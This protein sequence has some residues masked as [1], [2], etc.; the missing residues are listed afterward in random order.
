MQ[1]G[2][3]VSQAVLELL[4]PVVIRV[5]WE[6][7]DCQEEMVSQEVRA[8]QVQWDVLETWE[9]LV[10]RALQGVQVTLVPVERLVRLV[11]QVQLGRQVRRVIVVIQVT[12]V[13]AVVQGLRDLL[14]LLALLVLPANKA[15]LGLLGLLEQLVD[16]VLRASLDRRASQVAAHFYS[17]TFYHFMLHWEILCA[18]DAVLNELYNSYLLSKQVN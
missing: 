17:L 4:A 13:Q 10:G 15:A 18:V 11:L 12:R 16:Q 6:L 1:R 9:Q 14:D 2:H 7:L 8:L 5:P 3:Q